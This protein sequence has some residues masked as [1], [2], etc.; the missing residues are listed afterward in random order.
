MEG[1]EALPVM[2]RPHPQMRFS[3]P[4]LYRQ[5]LGLDGV[6]VDTLDTPPT[7]CPAQILVSDISGINA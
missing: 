6:K 4:E 3:Q 5:I 2:V 1:S 7:R